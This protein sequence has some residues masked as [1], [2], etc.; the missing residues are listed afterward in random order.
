[1]AVIWERSGEAFYADIDAADGT[2]H[3]LIVERMPAGGWDW[4][5][6]WQT[7]GTRGV[8]SGPADSV[9]EAMRKAEAAA[10]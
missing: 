8:H 3:H 1:M 6:W 7:D 4:S 2:R 10:T 5:V 9:Q